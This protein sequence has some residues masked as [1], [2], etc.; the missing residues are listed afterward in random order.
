MATSPSRDRELEL[1]AWSRRLEPLLTERVGPRPGFSLL[2]A[3]K[4][5]ADDTLKLRVCDAAGVP[6]AAVLVSS[7]VAPDLI[8]RAMERAATA[9]RVLGPEL[10]AAVI[11]PLHTGVVEG[12]SFC[13]LPYLTPLR[14]RGIAA[15][16]QR[17]WLAPRILDWL[18]GVARRTRADLGPAARELHFEKTLEHLILRDGVEGRVRAA[19]ERSLDEL[20][21]GKWV[22]R[23]VL[24]HGDLW[25]GNVLLEGAAHRAR[26]VIID[27][28]G[29]R[30]QGHA[31]F[32]LARFARSFR[33]RPG[34]LRRELDRHAEVLGCTR[35]QTLGH[36]LAALGS[37][38]LDL[39]HFPVA[40]YLKMVSICFDTLSE[41][42]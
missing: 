28:P 3:E 4:E 19:A 5:A 41:A 9:R 25:A 26:P 39:E 8:A 17:A 37:Q 32:D 34:R 31:I 20:R 11:E 33:I 1:S 10:G 30:V 35:Q 27:W 18:H 29:A 13:V 40:R 12:R 15:H 24:M 42:L 38:G 14:E 16:V 23:H 22:A 2:C 21:K 6:R 36:L 7:P